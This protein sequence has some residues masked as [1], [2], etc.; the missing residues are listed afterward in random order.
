MDPPHKLDV[1]DC[2]RKYNV[3]TVHRDNN[4]NL[5]NSSKRFIIYKHYADQHNLLGSGKRENLPQTV[6]S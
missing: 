5:T 6:L 2:M 1:E 4:G 3:N